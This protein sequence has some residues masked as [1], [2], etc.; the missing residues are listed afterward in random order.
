MDKISVQE[1]YKR[2]RSF[3]EKMGTA[4]LTEEQYQ[5]LKRMLILSYLSVDQDDSEFN[6]ERVVNL[7]EANLSE[8][9]K[10]MLMMGMEP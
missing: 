7:F 4:G 5:N 9:V 6:Q 8:Y 10:R 1:F 2:V 3:R